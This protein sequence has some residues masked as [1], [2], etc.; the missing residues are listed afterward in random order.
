MK[1]FLGMGFECFIRKL[2]EKFNLGKEE[3]HD[4]EE[5]LSIRARNKSGDNRNADDDIHAIL[6]QI[7]VIST[8]AFGLQLK[9]ERQSR[10]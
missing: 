10:N 8:L 9:I 2:R 6:Y 1:F 4:R 7:P 5:G 3:D